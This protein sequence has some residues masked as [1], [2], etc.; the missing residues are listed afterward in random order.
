[1]QDLQKLKVAAKALESFISNVTETLKKD[2]K[3]AL[4]GFRNI[5]CSRESWKEWV[6]TLQQSSYQ[7]P[8]KSSKFKPGAELNAVAGVKKK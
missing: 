5:L 7:N 3:V 2:G 8:A 6:I 1:M 4:V